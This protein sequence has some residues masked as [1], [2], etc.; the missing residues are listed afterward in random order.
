MFEVAFSA[1]SVRCFSSS[2]CLFALPLPL[3]RA[4]SLSL[5]PRL[6]FFAASGVFLT[7][8]FLARGHV[9]A[10]PAP[11]REHARPVAAASDQWSTP[12]PGVR[13]LQRTTTTPASIHAL[14]IDLT[15]PGVRVQTTRYSERWQTVSEY[16]EHSQVVA[17]TNGGFWNFMQK[18][19]G[20]TAGGGERWPDGEDSDEFGF[21]AVGRD[22]R[23]WISPPE[24]VVHSLPATKLAE[25][26][27]GK[28]MLVRNGQLDTAA[29]EAFPN[30][31]L[32]HPRTAVGVSRDGRTV[33]LI[34]VDG[35]QGFS[36]GMT[37]YELARTFVE[38][39]GYQAI[40]LDGGGSS[41]MFV[42]G[43]G[44]MVNSPSGGR[45]EAKLGLGPHESK[46]R[47][48]K[49]RTAETGEEEVY[50]RGIEREVMN[51]VGVVA[52]RAASTATN[53]ANDATPRTGGTI[54]FEQPTQP[55]MHL[56]SAREWLYPVSYG[57]AVLVPVLM[58]F[59][60]I[61]RRLRRA[62]ARHL[63]GQW[64]ATHSLS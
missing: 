1:A 22:N 64:P 35:R 8:V 57:A 47:I 56:G 54:Q 58:L 17:A 40:N 44:G 46:R 45:W 53:Q 21:F 36:R 5:R 13:Y 12:N 31:N 42:R 24:T 32:R 61:R 38:L 41:A 63:K 6:V 34:V 28:P 59:W 11:R 19:A 30:S 20:V 43:V 51:H 4:V 27:S 50:I 60:V 10:Q 55:R 16:A 37:L 7:H 2:V 14:V 9:A 33:I 26:V 3:I 52:P 48:S 18:A 62:K 39:G 25:A 29:L 49:T 23:A 15:V